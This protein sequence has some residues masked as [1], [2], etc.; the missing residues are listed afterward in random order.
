[1]T[2]VNNNWQLIPMVNEGNG[3]YSKTFQLMPSDTGAYYFLNSNAWAGRE[4]VPSLCATSYKTDRT[5]VVGQKNQEIKDDWGACNQVVTANKAKVDQSFSI[6]PNPFKES[7]KIDLEEQI[8]YKIMTLD[9]TIV[10][11]DECKEQCNI[12]A[13]LSA[14]IYILQVFSNKQS[15]IHSYKIIKE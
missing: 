5:Y 13:E 9:G 1:M 3:M 14:G 7:I 10:S 6:Y 4:S 8:S 12:G 2:A 11:E 15:I